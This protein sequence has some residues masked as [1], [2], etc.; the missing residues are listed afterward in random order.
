M[1]GAEPIESVSEE[2]IQE[3][4]LHAAAR[5][6]QCIFSAVWAAAAFVVVVICIVPFLAGHQ[7]HRY[8]E[9][10]K[11]LIWVA[12]ALWLWLI[13]KVGFIWAAWQSARETRREFQRFE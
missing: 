1:F 10:A 13:L 8:W 11:Y 5:L 2:E 3:F 4:E 6:K 7:F 12:M 9:I